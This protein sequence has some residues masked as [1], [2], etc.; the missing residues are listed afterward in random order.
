MLLPKF[1]CA[2]RHALCLV[3]LGVISAAFSCGQE[4]AVRVLA[5]EEVGAAEARPW[6]RT[7][8][9]SLVL[10]VD[11][12]LVARFPHLRLRILRGSP[13]QLA[14]GALGQEGRCWLYKTFR[15]VGRPRVNGGL[16]FGHIFD[17]QWV[18]AGVGASG[19]ASYT[20]VFEDGELK[21][22]EVLRIDEN[23]VHRYFAAGFELIVRGVERIVD[24]APALSI[25]GRLRIWEWLGVLSQK[26]N[27]THAPRIA[28]TTT[29]APDEEPNTAPP[30]RRPSRAPSV[31]ATVTVARVVAAAQVDAHARF[32][33]QATAQKHKNCITLKAATT[34]LAYRVETSPCASVL[35]RP[36]GGN[37]LTSESMLLRLAGT[38]STNSLATR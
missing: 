37:S 4:H 36:T 1:T 6:V 17:S 25:W 34:T 23:D 22:G 8:D 18:S 29:A 3:A 24:N 30:V 27:T 21:N 15:V 28:I 35:Q 11:A 31:A 32:R 20:V 10:H 38:H 5:E 26:A 33:A 19:E 14:H 16:D 13:N 9:E 2:G 7:V 12:N